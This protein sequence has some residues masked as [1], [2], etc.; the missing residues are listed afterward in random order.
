MFMQQKARDR[1]NSYLMQ[2][3]DPTD[4]RPAEDMPGKYMK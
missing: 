2:D 1:A 4:S 3:G